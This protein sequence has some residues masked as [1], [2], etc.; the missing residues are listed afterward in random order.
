MKYADGL[1]SAHKG[2]MD[3]YG[4]YREWH[5]RGVGFLNF[6]KKVGGRGSIEEGKVVLKKGGTGGLTYFHTNSF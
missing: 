2:S 3:K 1:D 6:S 5:D 4:K